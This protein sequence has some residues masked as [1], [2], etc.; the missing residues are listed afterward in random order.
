MFNNF[1][2][3][4]F[5]IVVILLV[6]SLKSYASDEKFLEEKIL[7]DG[8]KSVITIEFSPKGRLFMLEKNGKVL[9]F[10][11]GEMKTWYEFKDIE[12]GGEKGLL[13]IAF[14]PEFN[15]NKYVYFYYTVGR[16]SLRVV[17]LKEENNF[18]KNETLVFEVIDNV[19]ASNHNGGDLEFGEDGKL[20]LT[21]GDGGGMPGKR[22][23]NMNLALGKIIKLDVRGKLPLNFDS[24]MIYALGLRNSF[25]MAFYKGKL[26][27]TENGPSDHDEINLITEGSNY[28]WPLEKGIKKDNKYRNP[29]YDF[30]K[31]AV[32]PTGIVFLKDSIYV[33]DY[34]FGRLYKGSMSKNGTKILNFR[35]IWEKKERGA[36]FADLTVKGSKIYGAMFNKVIVFEVN[37]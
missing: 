13:G 19:W 33:S 5:I 37:D 4:F 21:I 26:F 12:T 18:G 27:A 20:Y 6:S 25:R 8:L 30:G 32:S 10:D 17:R 35:K 28:G 36:G 31:E 34:N 23:Q 2:K 16:N 7:L 29:I 11:K 14:D 24:T 9:F 15:K 1:F 3:S 22:S